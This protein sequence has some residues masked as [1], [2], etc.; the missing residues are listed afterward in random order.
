MT[1]QKDAQND[2]YQRPEVHGRRPTGTSGRRAL[3]MIPINKKEADLLGQPLFY[4]AIPVLLGLF[5]KYRHKGILL[6]ILVRS[7]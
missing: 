4:Y 7:E 6:C 3:G 1:V 2:S 5:V